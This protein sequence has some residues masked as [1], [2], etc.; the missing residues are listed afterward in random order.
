M[1]FNHDERFC[2]EGKT[3]PPGAFDLGIGRDDETLL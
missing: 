1:V 3:L 2:I